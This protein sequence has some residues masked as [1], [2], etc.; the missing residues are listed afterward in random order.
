MRHLLQ[1]QHRFH[2][3]AQLTLLDQIGQ[4]F[5][6]GAVGSSGSRWRERRGFGRTLG[7]FWCPCRLRVDENATGTQGFEHAQRRFAAAHLD[8]GIPGGRGDIGRCG[9]DGLIGAE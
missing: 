7:R 9:V 4:C 6:V 2:V 3:W 8:R 5:E 1:R